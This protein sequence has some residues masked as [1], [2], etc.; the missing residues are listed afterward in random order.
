RRTLWDDLIHCANRFKHD[1]WAVL[2]DFNVTRYGAEHSS[3]NRMT[4]AMQEFNNAIIK[5]ELEDLKGTGFHFTWNNMRMGSEAILKKLDRALGNW[6][7]FRSIGDSFAQFHPPGI[8][9]HSPVSIQLR[10][11]QPYKGRPFKFLNFWT[12]SEKF[13]HIV[14][15][16]WDKV[17]TGSPLIVIHKKLKSLKGPLGNLSTRPDSISKEPRSNYTRFNKR[18]ERQLRQEVGRA[19]IL[20]EAF[21][22]Q[23]SRIQW[24]KEGD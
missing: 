2:G 10:H 4:K 6:Q 12:D 13:L 19:A 17:Y 8:S 24:L 7:W 20:E 18:G 1:P 11:R 5:A 9:D 22:K 15:Q 23:K 16:E 3:S 14:K 21:F